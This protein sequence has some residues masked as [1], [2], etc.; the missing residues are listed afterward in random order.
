MRPIIVFLAR[1]MALLGGLVLTALVI[2]TCLSVLGRGLNTLG[3][4][5]LL[6]GLAPGLAAWLIGTGVGPISGD[7]ELVQSGMAFA[8]FAFLPIC[9]LRGAHATVGIFTD[10]LSP[11]TNAALIAFWE[12]VMAL[13]MLV[14]AWRLS[15]GLIDKYG[16]GQTT[17]LLQ[18][19]VW[20]SYAAS[21]AAALVAALVAL[22]CAVARVAEALT[23]QLWLPREGEADY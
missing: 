14:I 16:N 1:T 4:S 3:H 22:Y 7:F 8:V 5:D 21:L 11:R 13:V 10:P 15:V 6:E 17:F 2:L 9:Q 18:Y 20:W 19:P 23:G 12:V